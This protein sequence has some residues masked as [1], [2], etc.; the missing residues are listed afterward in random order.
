MFLGGVRD[1]GLAW[2]PDYSP[3]FGKWRIRRKHSN[4]PTIQEGLE[5]AA[6]L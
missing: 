4:L 5:K 6:R 3:T 1:G 2:L